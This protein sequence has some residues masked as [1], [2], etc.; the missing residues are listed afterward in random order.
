VTGWDAANDGAGDCSCSADFTFFPHH[1]KSKEQRRPILLTRAGVSFAKRVPLQTRTPVNRKWVRWPQPCELLATVVRA[2]DEGWTSSAKHGDCGRAEILLA[3]NVQT[4]HCRLN[5]DQQRVQSEYCAAPSC[6]ERNARAF[7]RESYRQLDHH[8]KRKRRA[9]PPTQIRPLK[10][11]TTSTV[12][13]FFR[14]RIWSTCF[15]QPGAA[16]FRRRSQ[17][18]N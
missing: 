15:G 18:E 14:V 10:N 11:R 2:Q 7:E 12:T 3:A 6:Q 4:C 9:S 1:K 16:W 8:S 13:R 17:G 5:T